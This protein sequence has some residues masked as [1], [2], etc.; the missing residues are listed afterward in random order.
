MPGSSG[1]FGRGVGID[2][3]IIDFSKAFDL[4]LHDRLFTKRAASGVDSRVVVWVGEFLVG[5][6]KG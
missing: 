3:I 5:R 1:L 4:V 2:A 6:H